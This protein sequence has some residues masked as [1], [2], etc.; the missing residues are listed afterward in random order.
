MMY[1]MNNSEATNA[2]LAKYGN[3]FPEQSLD[4]GDGQDS[5]G[6]ASL[7]QAAKSKEQPD[8]FWIKE[9]MRLAAEA[10]LRKALEDADRFSQGSDNLSANMAMLN[11]IPGM[12]NLNQQQAFRSRGLGVMAGR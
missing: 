1:G 9:G 4:F 6:G 10:E 12:A 3:L 5:A 2:M 7:I 11:A 8:R